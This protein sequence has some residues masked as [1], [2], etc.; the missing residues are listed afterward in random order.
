MYKDIEKYSKSRGISTENA[1][2]AFEIESEF[3]RRVLSEPDY[4]KR[5]QMYADVYTAVHPLYGK[6]TNSH[7]QDGLV[8]LFAKEL[9]NKSVLDVGCGEGH[10]LASIARNLPHKKLVGMDVSIPHLPQNNGTIK[11]KL[12]DVINFDL[13]EQFDV[14]F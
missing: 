12:G 1:V 4:E 3:H 13:Q 2:K 9:K 10:F 14:V 8:K 5:K 6:N 11:F 7:S